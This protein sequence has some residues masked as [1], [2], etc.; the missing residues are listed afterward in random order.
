[1]AP[2]FGN[3]LSVWRSY[4]THTYRGLVEYECAACPRLVLKH[5]AC[6]P[7]SVLPFSKL[8]KK[9]VGYFDTET[10]FSIKK[11][12]TCWGDLTDISSKKEAL[13]CIAC[14]PAES[15]LLLIHIVWMQQFLNMSS[16]DDPN[17][18]LT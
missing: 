11:I 13:P 5:A 16:I 7:A 3:C 8:N 9:C 14:A 17:S 6:T 2:R 10:T 4:S 12:N 18:I 15:S 1:M